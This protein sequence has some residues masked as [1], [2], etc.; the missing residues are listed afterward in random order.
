MEKEIVLCPS[1][2][3]NGEQCG[4]ELL[5]KFKRCPMCEVRVDKAWFQCETQAKFSDVPLDSNTNTSTSIRTESGNP[6]AQSEDLQQN[7]GRGTTDRGKEKAETNSL[8]V[9]GGKKEENNAEV[10]KSGGDEVNEES[11]ENGNGKRKKEEEDEGGGSRDKDTKTESVV[12]TYEKRDIE[13]GEERKSNDI[14]EKEDVEGGRNEEKGRKNNSKK[15]GTVEKQGDQRNEN[16]RESE[17]DENRVETKQEK[18]DGVHGRERKTDLGTEITRNGEGEKGEGGGDS[19]NQLNRFTAEGATS[20]TEK[21]GGSKS[22]FKKTVKVCFHAFLAPSVNFDQRKDELYVIF[23]PERNNW[24]RTVEGLMKFTGPK[25]N[26]KA[27]QGIPV[28]AEVELEKDLL[29]NSGLSYKY[30]F[31]RKGNQSQEPEF[32]FQTF[33][34]YRNKYRVLKVPVCL[35]NCFLFL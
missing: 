34:P 23:G 25:R 14:R 17:D 16:D 1:K 13:D 20:T 29:K 15:E 35:G 10:L 26:K 24:D 6:V 4:Y 3:A 32:I 27:K 11:G 18:E 31:H 12:D 5:S 30:C 8:G 33:F 9:D 21:I 19:S 7:G 28:F 22:D 2:E